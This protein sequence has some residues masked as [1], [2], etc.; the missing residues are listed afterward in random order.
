[1]T[2]KEARRKFIEYFKKHD[3]QVVRSS[4]LVPQ[5]DPT[6]LFTNA[7]MV[8][9][10][11]VFTGD[12]KRDYSTAVTAQKCVRAGGKH[13]D[14]ENVGYTAR[15]HTFFEM[16]GNFSFGDYFKEKAMEH[17]WNL[18]TKGYGLDPEKLWV[19]VFQ[20]DDE[21]YNLWRDHIGVPESR[22]VRLGEDD[23]FWA[24]GDTGP[25]GPC[26]EIHIDRGP[27]YGCDSPDCAVG[28]E[29]DRYLELWNLVFMQFERD[30][31]GKM[32]PLPKPSID[33][34]LGLERIVSVLQ[35][36]P[37]N[38][39]TD[40]F[41]PIMEKVE[42]LSGKKKS[43]SRETEVAMKVIADHSRAAAF[44]ICDGILPSNEGRGYVLRRIMRRAIRYGRYI[45]LTQSFLHE[46]VATV[47]DMMDEAYPELKDSAAFILNVVKNEEIKFSET[48]DVGLKLLKE[49][50]DK[51][52]EQDSPDKII[53]GD[54][55]FRLYD[56][57][58]FPVDII[59]DIL[60]GT[61]I[62]LDMEG[63]DRAMDAQKAR[64]KS[65]K[66][67]SGVAE[68]FKTLT[69][70]GVK[71]GFTGYDELE[72]QSP[73][74]LI[75]RD[76]KETE[77]AI[78][79]DEIEFVTERTPFYAESGGQAGDCG[80]ALPSL[81]SGDS[82]TIKINETISDPTGI[83]IHKGVVEEGSVKKGDTLLMKVDAENRSATALNHSATHILHAA[84]RSVLGDHVKQAGSLVT[85]DRLRFDF[86]HFSAITKEEIAAIELYVN[87]RIRENVP[88]ATVE[89]SMD[90]AVKSG[91]TA[92]F[93]EK[94]GDHV[95]VVSMGEFSRELCGG[96]HTS[97]TGNIGVF[98]IVSEAGIASGVR[99]IEA[100]TGGKAIEHIQESISQLQSTANLLKC[101]KDGVLSKVEAMI[102]DK[103][104]ADKEIISLKAKIASKSVE[105]IDS[106]I[107][108]INGVKVLSKQVE[109]DN[110]SQMRDLA[111]KFK[112][113]IGSGVVLLGAES[114]GKALLICVVTKD[115]TDRFHAGN[116]VKKAAA[117]VGGGGGG[118]PD[119]AQ[120]GGTKPEHLEAALNSVYDL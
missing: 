67:F 96:T 86:T 110:P 59:T 116:I 53:S 107:K 119:M 95:R 101:P 115:I 84:L 75:V 39:E 61:D 74:I 109:I 87:A 73:V 60:K 20:D 108:E 2:G 44:L 9:F 94:Y 64:S 1:M 31:T 16:L 62:A 23:N 118:R 14:L 98:Q 65:S 40:L 82:F 5:D 36:V 79:G 46:T 57:Y 81:S 90:D 114:G 51:L 47:F 37:T 12:E 43:D 63:Y 48:L 17:G 68:A 88:L 52:Q 56:T 66:T 77:I 105:S 33:T 54:V 7:G 42:L 91:A 112:A 24:M 89:M 71:T 26:S 69:S 106:E 34:G 78:T 49:T 10:K 120:A 92:L 19:S 99:R 11:R 27:E 72:T 13:N 32:T 111:D 8:Q 117:I 30:E 25:C 102:S 41:I 4:S 58:G 113:K 55:I 103:K 15:H 22:I 104:A 3:H 21:A 50:I 100:L 38:Y 97:R 45:G 85:C 76:G 93:E 18:L 6:L 83:R 29:C 28:C 80:V 70:Q 35:N